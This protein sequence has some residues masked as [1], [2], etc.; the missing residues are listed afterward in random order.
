[1]EYK[2]KKTISVMIFPFEGKK[3]KSP[4]YKATAKIGTEFTDVGW[5]WKKKSS[6]DTP[7][8]SLSL[9][10]AML[11]KIYDEKYGHYNS[12]GTPPPNFDKK[13]PDLTSNYDLEVTPE[14]N[15]EEVFNNWN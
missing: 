1:M 3:D 11:K 12:D 13:E 5:G 14:I 4:N 10:T 2:D 9:D 15:A 6:K 8:I 7:F